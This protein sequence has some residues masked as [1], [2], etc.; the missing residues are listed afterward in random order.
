MHDPTVPPRHV[1]F[2]PFELD[3]RSGELRKGSTRLK[4]PDQSIEILKALIEHPG[5]LVTREQLRERL[6]PANTF[7]DFEHGLNAAIRRLREALGDSADAPK[8]IETLPRR[9]YRFIGSVEGVP[10]LDAAL[11]LAAPSTTPSSTRELRTIRPRSRWWLWAVVVG[12]IV[13]ASMTAWLSRPA[14]TASPVM[15][16]PIDL[17]PD[18]SLSSPVLIS[19]NGERLVFLSNGRLV[20]RKLSQ[21]VPVPLAGTEGT[22]E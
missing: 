13:A 9:G 3:V 21:E 12:L 1:N 22:Q 5:E 4:V 11:D 20:T 8:Y 17:G 10:L 7:V 19:S 18:V 6:W 2:G 15:R 14:S 16:L